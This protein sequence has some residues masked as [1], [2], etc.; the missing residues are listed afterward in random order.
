MGGGEHHV[1]LPVDAGDVGGSHGTKPGVGQAQS[2]QCLGAAQMAEEEQVHVGCHLRM[3]V[4]YMVGGGD[5]QIEAFH[6]VVK[7]GCTHG[8]DAARGIA[9]AVVGETGHGQRIGDDAN[10]LTSKQTAL[11]TAGGHPTADGD[12]LHTAGGVEPGL[13]LPH[14]VGQIAR[15]APVEIRTMAARHMVTSATRR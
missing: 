10:A 11:A 6:G 2:I 14:A 13:G 8:D 9:R 1:A 3:M 4:H 15:P 7:A 12:K 5:H